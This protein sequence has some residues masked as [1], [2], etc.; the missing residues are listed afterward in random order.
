VLDILGASGA[1]G[2]NAPDYRLPPGLGGTDADIAMSAVLL[3]YAADVR[4]GRG[5]PGRD[6]PNLVVQSKDIDLVGILRNAATAPDMATFMETLP[7]AA[8]GY[9]ALRKALM[10]Y[11]QYLQL[12]EWQPV[13]TT[14]T[15]K[16][17]YAGPELGVLWRRLQ[18]TGDIVMD[19]DPPATF[20]ATVKQGVVRFQ[21]RNSLSPDGAVGKATRSALNVPLAQRIRQIELNMERWRW[22]PDDLGDAHVMVDLAAF[23][24]YAVRRGEAV[25]TMPIIVGRPYRQTPVFSDR[26]SYLEV[27]PTWTVPYKIATQDILP[28][29]RADPSYLSKNGFVVLPSDNG[30]AVDPATIDWQHYGTRNFP[31]QLRQN[32]GT[33]NALGQVKFMFPNKFSVYLHDTPAR[34]LFSKDVRMFSSGCI[35]VGK[36][37]ELA[38]FLLKGDP[39]WTPDRLHRE[40]ETGKTTII[41]LRNP[42]AVHLGYFTASATGGE[43]VQFRGDIY[44]R[45]KRLESY[46]RAT[47]SR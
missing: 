33:T 28:K 9:R 45:D 47:A 11:R 40:V 26:I 20:D 44:G 14:E 25:L 1:E 34:E 41:R 7:P 36:P 2:L 27:N 4:T 38:A 24:L 37:M 46:L 43:G 13:T 32:P 30:R 23:E 15:L 3:R 19:G 35:R 29:L 21:K 6:D 10:Q 39:A 5:T 31:F 18:R 42:V 16:P 17:G 22:M 8:E 12:G